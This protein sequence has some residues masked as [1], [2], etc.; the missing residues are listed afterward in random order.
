MRHIIVA[1]HS[2][3]AEGI[4]STAQFIMGEQEYLSFLCAYTDGCMDFKKTL[5]E[6]LDQFPAADEIIILTDLM[7]GSV[8][9]EA[10]QFLNRKGVYV[11]AGINLALL[12]QLLSSDESLPAEQVAADAIEAAKEAI[13]YCNPL[14][15][16][17]DTEEM[18]EF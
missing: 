9:N 4:V 3:M 13:V 8:N 15:Q 17:G 16:S 11:I 7:G 6:T 14:V 5:A 12:I 18:D 2:K 10:M 1:T